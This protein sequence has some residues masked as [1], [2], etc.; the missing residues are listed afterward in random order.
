[1]SY[2]MILRK[3]IPRKNDWLKVKNFTLSL[4]WA[5]GYK[6]VLVLVLEAVL[7]SRKYP[8]AITL[9]KKF[10]YIGEK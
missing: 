9:D 7:Y 5:V 8:S 6:K 2:P 10:P 4:S 1:M 3:N